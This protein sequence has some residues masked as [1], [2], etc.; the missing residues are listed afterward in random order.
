MERVVFPVKVE[1]V[2]KRA[3]AGFNL[4]LF[5]ATSTGE[6]TIFGATKTSADTQN[7]TIY[8]AV[9]EDG[10]MLMLGMIARTLAHELGHSAGLW[11]PWDYILNP[12][13]FT[14]FDIDQN[15]QD[16]L[17]MIKWNLMNSFANPIEE[18]KLRNLEPLKAT[19]ISYDQRKEI[20]KTVEA[21]Q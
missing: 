10:N 1:R 18:L 4:I 21:Q 8:L 20:Q 12:V 14:F 13:D 19:N 15:Y 16:D 7:N 11:H 6:G 5:D 9:S 2:R 17:E 3:G